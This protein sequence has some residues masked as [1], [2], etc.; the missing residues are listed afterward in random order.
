MEQ[1]TKV[2]FDMLIQRPQFQSFS[3]LRSTCSSGNSVRSVSTTTTKFC[4]TTHEKENAA[5]NAA[6]EMQQEMNSMDREEMMVEEDGGGFDS[7]PERR[8][9][10]EKCKEIIALKCCLNHALIVLCCRYQQSDAARSRGKQ[11]SA[12]RIR[13]QALYHLPPG[14]KP[15]LQAYKCVNLSFSN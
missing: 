6:A 8:R 2:K 1:R 10:R 15:Q 9:F 5:A 11:P 12:S 14:H 13:V 3:A 7:A 4:N